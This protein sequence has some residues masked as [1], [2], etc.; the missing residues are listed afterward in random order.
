M[1]T[2][3]IAQTKTV[4]AAIDIAKS[5]HEVL[6]AIPGKTRRRRLTVLNRQEDFDRLIQV[7]NRPGF[8]G[9]GLVQ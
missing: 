8:T 7:L 5:R 3:G 9:E 6:L 1:T 2:I 4:L